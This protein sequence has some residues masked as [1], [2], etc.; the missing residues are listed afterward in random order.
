MTFE[1]GRDPQNPLDVHPKERRYEASRSG[2]PGVA[3]ILGLMALAIIGALF[4]YNMTDRATVATDTRPTATAPTTTGA[5]TGNP[6]TP[7]ET[8]GAPMQRPTA[9]LPAPK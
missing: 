2:M 8:T 5:G 6:A 9:P 7:R 1:P 3:V 4:F